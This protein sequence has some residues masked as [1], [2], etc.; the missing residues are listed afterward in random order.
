MTK[1]FTGWHMA[2]ILVAFF[3]TIVAVNVTMARFAMSTFGGVTV[4][5]SYVASQ[6]FNRWLDEAEQEK[7]LGWTAVLDRREDGRVAVYL[8][9]LSGEAIVT[10]E[11]RHPLGREADRALAF[12]AQ[13][14][15]RYISREALPDGRWT[16]RLAAEQAGQIW[17]KEY[18]L[19]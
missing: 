11:A 3:G 5:N 9:G 16:L 10:A 6:E 12:T 2:A 15:G 14:D 7:A 13:G 18:P 8:T 4:E 19:Q 17:R 1:R